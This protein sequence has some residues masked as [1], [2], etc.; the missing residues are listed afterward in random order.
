MGI[1]I[2]AFS[3]GRNGHINR[4]VAN[5]TSNSG[6]FVRLIFSIPVPLF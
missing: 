1:G 6:S 4:N 5:Y 3:S 2:Q